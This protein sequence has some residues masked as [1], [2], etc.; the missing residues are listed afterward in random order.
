MTLFKHLRN[1]PLDKWEPVAEQH[2]NIEL[3]GI[4]NAVHLQ[5]KEIVTKLMAGEEVSMPGADY[6]LR[7]DH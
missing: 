6:E 1:E 7:M 5:H 3:Q 4:T 2:F